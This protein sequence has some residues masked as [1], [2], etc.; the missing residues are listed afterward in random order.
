[1]NFSRCA[2]DVIINNKLRPWA[3]SK[4]GSESG[5]KCRLV[6]GHGDV[7]I[8]L[9]IHEIARILNRLTEELIAR[10]DLEAYRGEKDAGTPSWGIGFCAVNS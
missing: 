9:F 7:D 1:M 6:I 2:S 8:A 5:E 3:D 10:T 4:S